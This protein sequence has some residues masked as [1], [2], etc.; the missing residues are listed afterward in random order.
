MRI[1][2]FFKKNYHIHTVFCLLAAALLVFSTIGTAYAAYKVASDSTNAI[3]MAGIKARI[4]E[5]YEPADSVFPGNTIE[6]IVNVKNTGGGDSLIRVKVEKAW[7]EER[8]EDGKLIANDAY[9]TDN[10]NIEYNT[11]YWFYDQAD[12]YF[13]Y[14]GVLKPGETTLAPLFEEFTVS[15][16]TG[17]EYKGLHADITVKMECVQAAF[18]GVSV[19][20]KTLSDLGINYTPDKTVDTVT[21]SILV[22]GE[23]GFAYNPESTDLFA[24]FKNLL[25]GETRS[26]IIEVKNMSSF[27]PGAEIFLRA[28]DIP[29]SLA[30]P[31]TLEIV[32]K[33]LHEYA[34]IVVTDEAGKIIYNGPIWGEPY[35]PGTNP[36]S[37]RNNISL[38]QFGEDEVKKLNVQLQVDPAMGDEYQELWG[39]I[40]WV[41]TAENIPDTDTI[42]LRGEK[43]WKHGANPVPQRPKELIIYVKIDG[44]I[45]ATETV[46]AADHW[47]WA[48]KL[49]KYDDYGK[50][51]QYTIDEE[52]IQGYVTTVNGTDV[53][54]THNTYE[55]VIIIGEKTWSHGANTTRRPQ[56]IIVTVKNGDAVVAAKRISAA[57]DWRWSFTFPKYDENGNLAVYTVDEENVPYYTHVVNGYYIENRFVSFNYPGDNPPLQPPK[58][59]DTTNLMLYITLTALSAGILATLLVIGYKIRRKN[60]NQ[61][62]VS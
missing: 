32:N 47:K 35:S 41:W 21:A 57:E 45:I 23:K 52:P 24:N 29:Q 61:Q 18:G 10:I 27:K 15:E 42:I 7:G 6:K 17:N 43:T 38:G 14:K 59:G 49:P 5:K 4:V 58:T 36:V 30:E 48:F 40:K 2:N 60:N 50:E 39:L 25:P 16:D 19:W 46:T 13:Y 1:I 44:R 54:N 56:S 51:I 3:S 62:L 11:E 31:G 20:D 55:E 28:E 53:T 22:G 34:T 37:M 12:G 8:G 33:L 26:Q 9:S